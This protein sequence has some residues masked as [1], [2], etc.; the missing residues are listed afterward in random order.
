M[1]LT[2]C[3]NT[4]VVLEAFL[5][6]RPFA[7]NWNK[8]IDGSC[9]DTRKAWISAGI[10]N[11]LIDACIIYMPLPLLWKLQIPIA[12]KIGITAMFGVGAV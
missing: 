4:V 2:L 12:K 10:I 8:T 5:L 7:Y 11:L 1:A 9:A 3:F 6:C